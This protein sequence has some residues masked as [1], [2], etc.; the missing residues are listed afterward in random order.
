M[1]SSVRRDVSRRCYDTSV[2][3]PDRPR[4]CLW[5]VA[6]PIGTR[7]DLSPRAREV[8][9][10]VDVVVAEDTRRTGRLLSA[11]GI[12]GRGRLLSLHEHNETRR[13]PQVLERLAAGLDVALASDAGTPVLSDPGFELVREAR[14]AGFRVLSVPGPSAF[15]AALAAAGQPP[16]PALLVGFLP[17]RQGARRRRVAE[18]AAVPATVV[19]FLSPHRLQ[20]ELADL[21]A[22]L[23]PERPATLLAELSKRYERA[24]EASLADLANGRE[25]GSPKGEYVLVIAPG[26]S[27]HESRQ[28]AAAARSAYHA[29]LERGLDRRAALRAAADELGVRRR[30][31]YAL[32]ERD[33]TAL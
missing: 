28:D 8:L 26:A 3:P 19:V 11:M 7:D 10:A 15:T 20:A 18:L 21:A 22:G 12:P 29:A 14:R 27:R 31:L 5:I 25:A 4:G 17:P 1:L 30:Q 2:S 33:E 9:A 13:V 6:T 23:G 32:L 24:E 16:L